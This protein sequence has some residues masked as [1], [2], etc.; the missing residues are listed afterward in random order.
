MSKKNTKHKKQKRQSMMSRVK[1]SHSQ[2]NEESS[3]YNFQLVGAFFCDFFY[4]I[5]QVL[6]WTILV[7]LI[8]TAVVSLVLFLR[9]GDTYKSYVKEADEVVESSQA[10]DFRMDEITY[11]Y[12][13]DG[14]QLASLSS[15]N[16]RSSYLKYK[17]IPKD[18]VNAFIAIEDRSF[19]NNIGIDVKGILRVIKD[20]NTSGGDSLAGAST[21]TQQLSRTIYLT[22][23]VSIKRKIKEMMIAIRL[24]KKYTKEEIME[25]YIN[26]ACF[27]N[28]IYGLEAAAKAFFGQSA[29]ELTLSQTAYL[30]AIPNRPEYFN[31]YKYPKRALARRDKILEDMYEEGYLTMSAYEGALQETIQIKVATAEFYNYETTYAVACAVEYLMQLH[32][33]EFRYE[34]SD[35]EDY[36]AYQESYESA[37]N[38][39]KTNLYANG[40]RITTSLQTDTQRALQQALDN[41][42]AFAT[43]TDPQT[44]IFEL[45]GAVTAIDNATGKVIAAVG[46]RSQENLVNVYSL[47]RAYQSYRQPGSAIKPLVVYTPALMSGYTPDST[48]YDIDVE[49]AQQPGVKVSDLSGP[50]MTLRSAVEQSKNGVAY[51]VFN[52]LGPA[53]GLE[54]VKNMKFDKIVPSDYTLSAALGG[55][56][57]GVTTVQMASGYSTLVN[58]GEYRN[59]SCIVSFKDSDGKELYQEEEAET[60][61]GQEASYTMLDILKGVLTNGTAK[62]MG[63]AEESNLAAAGKTGTTNDSKDGW[64]C[65]VTPYYSVAVWIGYDTPRTLES[66]YGGSYPA[67]V[68]KD[69]MLYLTKGMAEI[70]FAGSN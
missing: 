22:R 2:Q 17:D 67:S 31:P 59:P 33:F 13:Q 49:A 14:E 48:V 21:I 28:G 53:Y 69:A 46:G 29:Q 11:I 27:S 25:F 24:T 30:C 20:A 7:G 45:Q 18:A 6:K 63:W 10:E 9:F 5:W 68:W 23:D 4:Y 39:E 37:Y 56:T 35:E 38:L 47:N 19:W 44:N 50:S 36:Q 61:Y 64:F 66:L 3:S 8:S 57:Y 58:G 55:L 41:N 65:G 51:S 12:A 70:D 40:Y 26:T 42:L 1:K 15:G 54:C 62:S 16:G 60:V 43:Q 32:G 34:F 52:D